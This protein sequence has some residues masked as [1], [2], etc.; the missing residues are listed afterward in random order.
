MRCDQPMGLCQE[1]LNFL[2]NHEILRQFCP[3]CERLFLQELEIIGHYEG[4]FGNGYPLYRHQLK[5]GNCAD[6]F[7][8]AAIWDSGPMIY[9]GLRIGEKEILWSEDELE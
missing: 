9:L 2:S 6:E 1:A 3:C 4:M 5:D 7:V 8:Q